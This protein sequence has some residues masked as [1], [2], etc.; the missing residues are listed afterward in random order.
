MTNNGF[1][2]NVEW[3]INEQLKGTFDVSTSTAENDRAGRDRFNVV[4]MINSYTFDGTGQF[5]SSVWGPSK[6]VKAEYSWS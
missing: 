5:P 2:I 4:G 3:D 1:G 6:F